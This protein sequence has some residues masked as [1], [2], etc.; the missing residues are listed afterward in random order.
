VQASCKS[1]C[2]END[3]V[4]SQS[5]AWS[6]LLSDGLL[7]EIKRA[8]SN[9][10]LND[11]MMLTVLG[12]DSA[13]LRPMLNQRLCF[14]VFC[15]R[16]LSCSLA[17]LSAGSA[18][19][20]TVNAKHQ[21]LDA[22]TLDVIWDSWNKLSLVLLS[23]IRW[24]PIRLTPLSANVLR[25]LLVALSKLY[26][27]KVAPP[28]AKAKG[29]I[30]AFMGNALLQID[31]EARAHLSEWRDWELAGFRCAFHDESPGFAELESSE[32]FALWRLDQSLSTLLQVSPD[33]PVGVT[34]V[35]QLI[36]TYKRN[37]DDTKVQ[38][39]I[40]FLFRMLCNHMLNLDRH[41][42]QPDRMQVIAKRCAQVTNTI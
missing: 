27:L 6:I 26:G 20:P 24:P 41:Y 21:H 39:E 36:K 35:E 14:D 17:L 18:N 23:L 1:V 40:H 34:F 37:K 15:D 7:R 16:L 25:Q 4:D 38:S 8:K 19:A 33:D 9:H 30:V 11:L 3:V 31:N 28:S 32:R 10:Y 2:Q 12:L 29:H 13:R 5:E 22:A 42:K